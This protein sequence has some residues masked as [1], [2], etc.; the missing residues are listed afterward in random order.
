MNRSKEK[1]KNFISEKIIEIVGIVIAI[2]VV[3]FAVQFSN[4]LNKNNN[5]ITILVVS[6]G[7]ASLGFSIFLK[8]KCY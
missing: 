3:Y 4:D 8:K 6:I 7:V 5:V 1:I 2:L